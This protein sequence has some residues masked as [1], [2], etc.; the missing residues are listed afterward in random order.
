M[1]AARLYWLFAQMQCVQ[2]LSMPQLCIRQQP[3]KPFLTA[4]ILALLPQLW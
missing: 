4:H 1:F 2:V 3:L